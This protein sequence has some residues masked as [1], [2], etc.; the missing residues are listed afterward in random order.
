MPPIHNVYLKI[1]E[2]ADY[3]P[4][5]PSPHAAANYRRDCMRNPGHED[6]KIPLSEVQA[7]ELDAL[8]YREYLDAGYT[9]PKP[10]KLI[11]A[12][13]NEPVFPHRVP[14]T[15]IYTRPGEHLHIH[16][17]NVD[18][19]PHSFHVHGLRYGIESDGSWPLG[20]QATDGR[21][22]DEI[23]PGQT[24]IYHFDV[25]EEMVGAWP[26][27]EHYRMIGESVNRG[28]FGGIV[29]LPEECDPPRRFELPPLV[30]EFRKRR[31]KDGEPAA[32]DAVGGHMHGGPGPIVDQEAYAV[33][34]FLEEW[35]QLAYAHPKIED[36]DRLHVPVFIHQMVRTRGVPTFDSGPFPP[37]ALPFEVQL[38]AEA[39]YTYHCEIHP[40]MQ[41]KIVVAAGEG[42]E[43]VV[44][45]NDTDPLNMKF[46][47]AEARIRPGG[48]VRWTSGTTTHIIVDDGAGFPSFCLNGRSFVGNTPT[49]VANAGQRIRWYVFNLGLS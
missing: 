24:W 22:S 48:K 36:D 4:V 43:Q 25:T 1:E 37:G 29:V 19:M 49:I 18:V 34:L 44:T 6:A 46:V 10:D 21:R 32:H 12:D 27:H 9:I 41:G 15:V 23:C 16:V 13:V 38:G 42:P 20:T 33:Q 45:I 8:I 47:P 35:A 40:S 3:S 26:F 31:V 11:Q 28:L 7:R 17:L 30:E 39:T 5:E 2:I 14:G